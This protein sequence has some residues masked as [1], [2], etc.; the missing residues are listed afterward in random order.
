MNEWYCHG[1]ILCGNLGHEP[2]GPNQKYLHGNKAFKML[3]AFETCSTVYFT[4][5]CCAE[6]PYSYKFL[7][8]KGVASSSFC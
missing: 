7:V 8:V 2:V 5:R 4:V 6:T 1:D 3:R